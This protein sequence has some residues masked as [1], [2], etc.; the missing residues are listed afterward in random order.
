MTHV[1]PTHHIRCT[2]VQSG[3]C[4]VLEH[5]VRQVDPKSVLEQT[6]AQA[7]CAVLP[8]QVAE[9]TRVKDCMRLA[10]LSLA[11]DARDVVCAMLEETREGAR[12]TSAY[13]ASTESTTVAL[14]H[15]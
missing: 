4:L 8:A 11:G 1:R 13:K 2:P 10:Q 6:E 7:D 15:G 14:D 9:A 5:L 3:E 12:P